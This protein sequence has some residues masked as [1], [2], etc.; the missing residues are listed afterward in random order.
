MFIQSHL[1]ILFTH[2]AIML[3]ALIQ[4]L[5][6]MFYYIRVQYTSFILTKYMCTYL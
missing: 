2:I 1:N 3:V 5:F 6:Y 4:I